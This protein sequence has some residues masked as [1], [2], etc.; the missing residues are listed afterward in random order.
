MGDADL[1]WPARFSTLPGDS[2]YID[3][4]GVISIER[5]IWTLQDVMYAIRRVGDQ[6]LIYL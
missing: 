5:V 6:L 4:S 3:V 2:C 1:V